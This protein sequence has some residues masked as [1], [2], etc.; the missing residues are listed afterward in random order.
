MKQTVLHQKHLHLKAKMTDF[1]GWEV[2]LQY[3]D[4]LDEY[5]AVRTAAGLFDISYLGR[6]EIA[7]QGAAAFLQNIFSRNTGKMAAGSAHYGFICNESGFV[8]DDAVLSRLPEGQS[9]NRYILSTNALNT[10]KIVL[11]LRQHASPQSQISVATEITAHLSLQGPQAFSILEKLAGTHLKKIKVRS[12]R[13]LTILDIPVLVSRTGYTGEHGY[14]FFLPADRAETFWDAILNAGSGSGLLPCGLA[15]R[16]ILRMEMGY[17]L[18]GNDIDE[19]RTPLEAG[20]QAFIDFKKEFIGKDALLKLK[21][22]G[23]KQK[24]S[25]FVL[26][27]K[28]VPKT[29][30]SIFSENREI[31]VVTSGGHSPFLRNGIG[32]GYVV[33]RYSQP[34][35]EIEIEVKDREIAAKIV[36]LPFYRKK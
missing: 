16:D 33:S 15:S 36:E 26:L 17:L 14:E 12:M 34:G 19:T 23:V 25:G 20:L 13:E 7:G 11:W 1:Q 3:T 22:E 2:P 29:G 9:G 6:I 4:V 32:L 31:G 24:L 10:E 18:Y 35:Q 30:G 5:H 28:D 27:D 21:A 8:L